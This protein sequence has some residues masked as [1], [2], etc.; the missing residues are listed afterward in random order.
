VPVV[1]ELPIPPWE[2]E[3]GAVPGSL[4]KNEDF[5]LRIALRNPQCSSERL[6]IGSV[7]LADG[8]VIEVVAVTVD[9]EDHRVGS[10]QGALF[11]KLRRAMG[12][13]S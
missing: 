11:P 4:V 10:W 9:D 8:V 12:G 7:R 2:D 3:H 13:R 1:V 6:L 5:G